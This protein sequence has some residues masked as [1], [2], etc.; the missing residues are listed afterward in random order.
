MGR[1]YAYECS[2]CGFQAIISGG[3]DRGVM[4]WVQTIA[5]RD[6]KKLYDALTRLKA[7]EG[8]YANAGG[9]PGAS[10]GKS[11]LS[12]VPPPAFPLVLNRL[13]PAGLKRFRWVSFKLQCPASPPHRV[14]AWNEPDR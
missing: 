9:S 2:K 5:C 7:P 14:Q 12:A 1:S 11:R 3:A 10:K 8:A 13:H 4:A 6:C